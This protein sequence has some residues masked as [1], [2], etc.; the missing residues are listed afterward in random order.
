MQEISSICLN[1]D[2]HAAGVVTSEGREI[3]ATIVMSNATPHVTF[4]KLLPQAALPEKFQA[5]IENINYASPVTKNNG[6]YNYF[7]L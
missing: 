5:A 7:I 3:K 6:Q 2:G 1:G 4:Q